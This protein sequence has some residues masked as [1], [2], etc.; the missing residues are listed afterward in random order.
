MRR[1]LSDH[2]RLGAWAVGLASSPNM[3]SNMTQRLGGAVDELRIIT[4]DFDRARQRAGLSREQALQRYDASADEFLD[5]RGLSMGRRSP[6]MSSSAP[7][8]SAIQNADAVERL[9][10]LPTIST[11]TSAPA[12][13]RI[14]SRRCR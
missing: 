4:D 12:R 6:A 8:S 7:T 3:R 10:A 11:A 5:G 14:S 9:P 2:R 13:S 1:T